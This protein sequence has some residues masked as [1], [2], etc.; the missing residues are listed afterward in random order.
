[1]TGARIAVAV[2]FV[3]LGASFIASTGLLIYEF[4]DSGWLTMLVA[5]SHLFFFFP[6]L[7]VLAL[8]AFY[9]PAVVFTHFYWNHLPL[10]KLPF[11]FGLVVAAGLSYYFA[12]IY[13][14]QPP[15]AIWEVSPAAL[16]ADRGEVLSA[17][18][19]VPAG[20]GTGVCRRAPILTALDNLRAEAQKRV[21][22]SKF[23]RPCKSDPLLEPPEELQEQRYCFP[24]QARLQGAECCAVQ[25]SFTR[26]VTLLQAD[27]GTRSL[28]GRLDAVFLP[29]KVFFVLIVVAIGGLLALWRKRIDVHYRDLGPALARGVIIGALAMLLWPIMDYGYQ[30]TANALFGREGGPQLRLSLVIAPWVLMLLFYFL[31]RLGKQGE[32]VGQV[33]GVVTA[34]VAVLRYEDLN[35]WALR[36]F[37]VGAS[38]WM[39]A[40]I[41]ALA[42]GGLFA[43]FWRRRAASQGTGTAAA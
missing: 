35:D 28:S 22:L 39:I 34:G 23:A 11:L 33:A 25:E 21:G 42:V 32:V 8:I 26:A 43:R 2:V 31:H 15:R 12:N 9:L 17:D 38:W 19:G 24:A 18:R 7:G 30:Q 20:C 14:N 41:C 40:L 16:A 13:L 6:V 4:R 5:H 10:G 36:L 29:L 27:P 37:G 1:M 3:L